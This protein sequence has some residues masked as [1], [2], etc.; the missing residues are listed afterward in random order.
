MLLFSSAEARSGANHK[1]KVSGASMERSCSWA[2]VQIC[3]AEPCMFFSQKPDFWPFYSLSC[4]YRPLTQPSVAASNTKAK[5]RQLNPPP[6][7][8][9]TNFHRLKICAKHYLSKRYLFLRRWC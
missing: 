1:L 4:F 9:L 8:I 2:A 3:S 6:N 5:S 7:E